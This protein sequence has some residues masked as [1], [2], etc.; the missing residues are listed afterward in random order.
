[1]VREE[2]REEEGLREVMGGLLLIGEGIC[3]SQLL[4]RGGLGCEMG[5]IFVRW[6]FRFHVLSFTSSCPLIEA[7]MGFI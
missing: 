7:L 2:S 5:L 4:E 3:K 6:H 1:M